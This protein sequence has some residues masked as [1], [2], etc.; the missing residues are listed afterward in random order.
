MT[1][2]ESIRAAYGAVLTILVLA[3]VASTILAYMLRLRA[4]AALC[5]SRT[6]D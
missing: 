6:K 4:E 3:A 5:A 1:I 2:A